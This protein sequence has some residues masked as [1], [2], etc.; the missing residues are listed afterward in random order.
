MV[1]NMN[2]FQRSFLL[3]TLGASVLTLAVYCTNAQGYI[4]VAPAQGLNF[5]VPV[6]LPADFGTGV[7]FRDFD[8]DGWDDLTF[9]NVDD[10][11]IFYRN[12]NGT[13]ERMPSL[14]YAA[15]N[16]RTVLWADIDN[17]GDDDLLVTTFN[18]PVKLYR[19]DGNWQ[20][21][22]ITATSGILAAYGKRWG[23]SFGDYNKD[24]FLDLYVCT[25]IYSEE[26]YAYSKLNHLYRNNGN[27]TFTDVTLQAGVGD[28][29]KASFQS[30]WMDVDLDGWPDLF[31]I[32][33][34]Q[35]SNS[36][37]RNNGDGTFTEMAMALGLDEPGEHCMSISMCDFDLDGDL[38]IYMTNTGVFLQINN[39]RHMLMLNN[40]DGT[41]TESSTLYGLNVFEWGWGALWVDHDNDGYQDMYIATHRELA[42]AVPN[43]FFKNNNGEGFSDA[44]DLF[45][46]QQITSSHS[47]ARGDLNRDGY[48]DIAVQNQHPFAP[49]VWQNEGGNANHV[50]ITLEGTVSNRMAIGSWIK[51]Y[52]GGKQYVH[53]TV[54]GENY[55]SQNSQHILFGLGQAS[56]VDSV[57]VEYP[58]GHVDRYYDLAVN[59]EYHFKEG[60]SMRPVIISNAG[61]A[62]C[63]PNTVVLDAGDHYSYLWNTGYNG[64]YLEV[65]LSGTYSVSVSNE[66]GIQATSLPAVVTIGPAPEVFAERNDPVCAGEAT[67]SIVLENLSGVAVQSVVWE[68]G[69]S[70]VQLQG[71]EEG[72][73]N[74][75]LTDANNCAVEGS[76]ELLDPDP[77]FVLVTYEHATPSSGG[78]I[79]WFIFGG[80]P[81]YSIL[82]N[83][84][85]VVEGEVE[86]LAPGVYSLEIKDAHDCGYD[87]EVIIRG[88]TAVPEHDP[89]NVSLYPN[90]VTDVLYIQSP[91]AVVGA[92]I[93]DARGRSVAE[94]HSAAGLD[95][96]E[97]SPLAGGSY[98]VA[99]HT[100][101][102]RVFRAV[103]TKLDR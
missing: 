14:A 95:Q 61:F 37:Y 26:N 46:D 85:D 38:D 54:C 40:G 101:D 21:V 77:L 30:V 59:S 83:D 93:F 8:G 12:N 99:L 56:V 60:G 9:A 55:L 86:D 23:A 39:G 4:N 22:D 79:A 52:A 43:L 7:S 34:F 50:R 1:M 91:I 66:F 75:E 78:S 53:Y 76:V 90:P 49:Y 2:I 48:A 19:N 74:Y 36:L 63:A 45:P 67:G 33:D 29:M 27:G 89:V 62:T 44:A 41:Y 98:L 64:R 31:V 82:L 20:F 11:L 103:V 28:G 68:H 72:V 5:T 87:E 70:G 16:T 92:E 6:T 51:V 25:Y 96:L 35:P 73:Y 47:V 71:L 97:L 58:S 100:G 3:R 88:A 18:G 94:Q 17:D 69:A 24:G 13:L 81:P 57:V 10:S 32:N 15:G 84:L 42:L 80:V 65:A 102:G